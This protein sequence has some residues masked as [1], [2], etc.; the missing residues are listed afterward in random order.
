MC[1]YMH[2]FCVQS[3]FNTLSYAILGNDAAVVQFS[4]FQVDNN[5]IDITV[6]GNLQNTNQNQYLVS[7][8]LNYIL[9]IILKNTVPVVSW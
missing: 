8:R 2:P 3:P 1:L 9:L 4:F 7:E 6:R 5:N